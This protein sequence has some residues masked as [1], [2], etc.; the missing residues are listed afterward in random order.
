M[1]VAVTGA[2]GTI[3]R[4]LVEALLDRGDAVTVLTRNPAAGIAAPVVLGMVMQLAGTLGGMEAVRPFLLSTP[5][6]AWHGL[7][8]Q[9]PFYSPLVLG[10]I[11]SAVW[12]AACLTTAFIA[13]RRRDITGG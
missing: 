13:L 5:F 4:A 1:R 11:A 7:L 12:S 6:E 8:A 3:G 10:L 2:T 9:Q